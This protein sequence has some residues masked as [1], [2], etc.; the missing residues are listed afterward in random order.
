M[1]L[2]SGQRSRARPAR[3]VE[4][5]WSYGPYDAHD[6][7]PHAESPR[8]ITDHNPAQQYRAASG[9]DHPVRCVGDL[10]ALATARPLARP[11]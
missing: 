1:A 2:R 4:A 9:R 7:R 11:H 6:T 10:R 5:L 3:E 8:L